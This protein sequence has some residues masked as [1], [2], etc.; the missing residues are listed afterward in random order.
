[1]MVIV[2]VVLGAVVGTAL[3]IEDRLNHLGEWAQKKF[4]KGDSRFAEGFVNATLL[5]AVGAMAVV[6]SLE[7]GLSNKPDTLLAK[8]ALDAVSAVI[9]GSTFGPG[10]ILSAVPLTLYQGG[11]ALLAGSVAPIMTTEL[12]RELS[13]VGSVLIVALGI[14]MLGLMKDRI[15]VGNMLPA[16][17]VPLIYYPIAALL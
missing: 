17:L 8:S 5:F 13:A 7:A 9:F 10:V 15:H 2:S 12:I 16:M 4:S 1:M 3:K 14:N 11:I 6:G